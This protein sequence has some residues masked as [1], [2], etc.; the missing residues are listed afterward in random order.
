ME[1]CEAAAG[2]LGSRAPQA[3]FGAEQKTRQF[4]KSITLGDWS[5]HGQ[6]SLSGLMD[7]IW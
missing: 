4:F 1:G 7:S 5:P 3:E 2:V 6:Y